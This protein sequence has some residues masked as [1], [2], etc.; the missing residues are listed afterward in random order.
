M[1]KQKSDFVL[2]SPSFDLLARVQAICDEYKYS[3]QHFQNL[4]E[5]MEGEPEARFLLAYLPESSSA[6]LAAEMAQ[7]GRFA[8]PEAFIVCGVGKSLGKDGAQFAKKSGANL[9]LLE[10]EL[11]N[12]A[13]LEFIANQVIR[14][15]YLPMKVSDL[16]QDTPIPFDVYHLMPQRQKFLKFMFSGDTLDAERLT[17]L[18]QVGEIYIHRKDAGAYKNYIASSTD[19]SAAGLSKRCRAQFLALYESYSSL[20]FL[21][22]DQSETGSFKEGEKMLKDCRNLCAEL[23]GTLAEFGNAWEI[24]N[25]ST[26]GEFGSV[27]RAPAIASYAALF[28]LQLGFENVSNNMLAALLSDLG[29]LFLPPGILKK[30]REGNLDTLT[31]EE[32]TQFQKY[33]L[34]SLDV[35]LDRKLAIEEKLRT[36][37]TSVRERVD[38][39]GFP[40]GLIDTKVPL[41]AQM[42]QLSWQ[43]DQLT[44]L[45]MGK[46]RVA[47]PLEALRQLV[48]EEL[49]KPGRYSVELLNRFST[50]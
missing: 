19:R 8:S 7:A 15:A 16:R 33:P 22:T 44:L 49:A 17:K 11:L 41:E 21:L 47:D 18:K 38:G 14:A 50:I 13:K 42:I 48:R 3:F 34:L 36:V 31:A 10:D 46:A 23:L 26:I 2:V 9:I 28:S 43:F 12:T 5:L 45:R 27:E 40:K 35:I 24:I 29:L 1:K 20:V 39:K 25:N 32:R 37:I 6:A 4:E 30:I